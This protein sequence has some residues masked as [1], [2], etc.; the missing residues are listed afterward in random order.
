MACARFRQSLPHAPQAAAAAPE[1]QPQKFS[2]DY[3]SHSIVL[4]SKQS[5]AFCQL[6]RLASPTPPQSLHNST[7]PRE[8][9]PPDA[10]R[11][12]PPLPHSNPPPASSALPPSTPAF[13]DQARAAQT[14]RS[15][16]RAAPPHPPSSLSFVSAILA[17]RIAA[18]IAKVSAILSRR[19]SPLAASAPSQTRAAPF[20]CVTRRSATAHLSQTTAPAQTT[21]ESSA[22]PTPATPAAH[23]LD[24]AAA[25]AK[26]TAAPVPR[27]F[28]PTPFP[29][30]KLNS[31][32][33]AQA[34]ARARPA[35]TR[36]ASRRAAPAALKA[37]TSVTPPARATS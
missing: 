12:I 24:R 5:F 9:S 14:I 15:A 1:T 36:A 10:Y 26:T 13:P 30:Q 32:A 22:P 19:A 21:R 27:P 37:A 7:A 20:S 17:D 28:R 29:L 25:P 23:K 35:P 11:L 6:F 4:R 16:P 2:G 31:P 34:S 33:P 18:L 8:N 3:R